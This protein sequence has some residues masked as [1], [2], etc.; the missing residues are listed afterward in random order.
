MWKPYTT[1]FYKYNVRHIFNTIE[2][3]RVTYFGCDM[4]CEK[5]RLSFFLNSINIRSISTV[6]DYNKRHSSRSCIS[7]QIEG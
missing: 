3:L 6:H 2:M 4:K 5:F 7:L 1:A